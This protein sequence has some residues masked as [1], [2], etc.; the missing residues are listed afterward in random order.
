[1]AI[2]ALLIRHF[3][4]KN[5]AKRNKAIPEQHGVTAYRNLRY[6]KGHGKWHKLDVYRPTN[7]KGKLPLLVVVHGGGWMYGDKEIYAPYAKNLCARG[8]AVVCFSYI[9]AP[10][11]KFPSQLSDLDNVLS[12]VKEHAEEYGFDLDNV[13]LV[14]DS[15][16]ASLSAQY[17]AIATNPEYRKLF[18]LQIRVGIRGLGLNCGLYRTLGTD[19]S[20]LD[21]SAN[22]IWDWYLGKGFDKK[23]P[24]YEIMNNMTK[25]FPPAYLLTGE[26]DFIKVMN[27][28]MVARLK[29]LKVPYVFKEYTSKE[30]DKLQHVFYCNVIEEHAKLAND[31]ECAFFRK[32]IADHQ[33][34]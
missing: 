29:E 4:H 16:G 13:F 22:M 23:D 6:S 31:E 26:K 8:F 12:F 10:E 17:A 25:D 28:P 9:L 30:G 19:F 18:S 5:D 15:S 24:R 7:L 27:A 20:A 1:M 14:G 3:I 11:A 32:I 21:K 2:K 34:K 33:A